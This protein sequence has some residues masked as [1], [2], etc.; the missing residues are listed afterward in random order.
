[1]KKACAFA[2]IVAAM[3]ALGDPV[4]PAMEM[5]RPGAVK[6]A[7]WL[8]DRAQAAKDG[9]TGHMD[10]VDEHFRVAWST[11]GIR[12]GKF[13][14]W[15]NREKGSWSSEG[16]AYWF[17]GLVKL[18]WQLDDPEL[19][20]MAKR[21][22]DPLL[23]NVNENSMGFIWWLDRR[24]P[25]QHD[26]VFVDATWQFWVIGMS[27]RVVAAYYEATGDERAK[28]ALACAFD[29]EEMARKHGGGATFTSGIAEVYRLTGSA[30]VA[31][32][33]DLSCAAVTNCQ[34]GAPP[35]PRLEDTLN[36]KRFHV[37]SGVSFPT[38]HGVYCAEQLM[39]VLA[40]YRRTGETSLRDAVVAWYDFL[41]RYC[42]QPYGVSMM[43]EEWGWAGANRGTE[44]CDVAAEMYTRMKLLECLGDGRWADDVERAFFNAGPGCLSRDY[45]RHVYHQLPNRV[46]APREGELFSCGSFNHTQFKAQHWPLCCSA[47]LNRILPNYVLSMW[48]KTADGGVAATLYGPGTFATELKAGRAAFEEKT[49]YPFDETIEIAVKEAPGAAFPLKVRV[50]RW[51]KAP[52][53]A[54][55][56]ERVTA[57][58]ERGFVSIARVW[59]TGDRVALRLPMQPCVKVWRDMNDFGRERR[60]IYLG[61]LLFAYAVPEKDDN[62]P[63]GE[64]AEP[65][66]AKGLKDTDILVV[67][68]PLKRPW[69]WAVADAPVRLTLKDV[70]GKPLELVPYGC[71]KLHISAFPTSD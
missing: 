38:R 31:K 65:V 10:D 12:R 62:T 63:A 9:F 40:A 64:T 7:G 22:L 20:A 45:R 43:D 26:E 29:F 17:D 33:L 30:G 54:V 70:D 24:D 58:A 28:R 66:L 46:S 13:L 68:K 52:E 1:M 39:S 25:A 51:C 27:A 36:L 5:T 16:G 42:A 11:N 18:A 41:D 4:R 14:S 2:G 71:A 6:P 44:T 37:Q 60:S 56:G 55:N 53:I 32:C 23:E 59:K 69:S 47:A 57:A 34:Y 35:R 61:P 21:R 8:K 50:P 49:D 48:M 15:G 3:A 19:K 67:R